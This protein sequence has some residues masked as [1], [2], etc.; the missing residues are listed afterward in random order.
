MKKVSKG[1]FQ[2]LKLKRFEISKTNMA[3]STTKLRLVTIYPLR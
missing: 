3:L 2:S 1:D